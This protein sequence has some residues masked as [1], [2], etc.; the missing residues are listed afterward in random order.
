M[1]KL[2][3]FFVCAFVVVVWCAVGFGAE[4]PKAEAPKDET[5]KTEELPVIIVKTSLGD[6]E[7]EL[8]PAKAPK[9]VEN[10]L[11]YVDEKFFDGTIFHRVIKTFMIQGGGFTK[12]MNQK[13]TKASIAN[14]ADNGLKNERGTIAMA[15]TNEPDSAT[16]QFFINVVD[17]AFLNHKEKSPR[18]WGYCVFGR[19]VSGMETADKIRNVECKRGADGQMSEPMETV[20]IISIRRKSA[21]GEDV[22]GNAP[23]IK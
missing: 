17:N 15:R 12:D 3:R 18:G 23:E 1:F 21:N 16:A 14:E 11:S 19:V 8:N 2:G 13:R 6:M 9:T 4:T 22:P 5:P 7:I 10:F 20:E